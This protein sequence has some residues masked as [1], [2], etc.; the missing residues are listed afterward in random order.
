VTKP[1][2]NWNRVI[3][4]AA[5][6][7]AAVICSVIAVKKYVNQEYY[8]AIVAG[9]LGLYNLVLGLRG[10]TKVSEPLSD[11]MSEAGDLLAGSENG[12][13]L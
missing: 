12:T 8:H 10:V 7:A 13:D 6:C 2:L 9:A 1:R 5:Y 11:S 4:L 3:R